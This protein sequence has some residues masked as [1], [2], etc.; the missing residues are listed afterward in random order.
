MPGNVHAEQVC[1][2]KLALSHNCSEEEVGKHLPKGTV[3]YTTVEPCNKR[4]SENKPCVER[5]LGTK[6]L[7]EGGIEKVYVGVLEPETFVGKNE[8]RR[9]LEEGGVEVV[10]VE[11]LEKEILEVATKGHEKK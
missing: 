6:G 1:L 10:L 4:L 11:G 7:G 5:I 2:Q 8:G 9:R 3:L